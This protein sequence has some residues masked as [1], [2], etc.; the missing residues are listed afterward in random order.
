MDAK[1]YVKEE[2]GKEKQFLMICVQNSNIFLAIN[3]FPLFHFIFAFEIFFSL[4][5]FH[6]FFHIQLQSERKGEKKMLI[7]CYIK[8]STIAARERAKNYES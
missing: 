5:L 1:M 6:S 2:G 7:K 8:E 3:P 4:S